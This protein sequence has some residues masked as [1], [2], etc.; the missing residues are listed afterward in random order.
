MEAF[1]VAGCQQV[2]R[3]GLGE[4]LVLALEDFGEFAVGDF[5]LAQGTDY[6]LSHFVIGMGMTCAA[7]VDTALPLVL[8]EPEV[9]IHHIFDIDKVAALLAV[10]NGC[11]GNLAP[12]LKQPCL[13]GF[14]DLIVQ[15][16]EDGGHLALMMFLW[17]VN[18]E[19]FQPH[20]LALRL[21]HHLT[22]ISVKGQFGKSIGIQ[23]ILTLV[24]LTETVPAAAVSGR[25]RSIQEG[26][27][28]L[29]AE[30]QQ[31]FGILIVD[32]HHV[33]YIVFHRVGAGPFME[34]RIN[35]R[36]V[37]II[38]FNALQ[39]IVLVLV[40]NEFQAAQ[41]LVVLPVLQVIYHQYIR[42]PTAIE[43][44]HQIAADKSGTASYNNH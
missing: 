27:A 43:F 12:A 16:I 33:V 30:M 42:P 39:K 24:P 28:V 4:V 19:V 17:A 34:Y 2:C 7:V 32:T 13:A 11:P 31:G 14:I 38:V 20:N 26:N 18:I 6:G 1:I 36:A 41:V 21:G 8:P 25:R 15:L 10:L 5:A 3:V 35:V 44:L 9:H 23:G 22:H 29:Q 37:K 40:V